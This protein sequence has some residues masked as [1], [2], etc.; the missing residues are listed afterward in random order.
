MKIEDI[1]QTMNAKT[2]LFASKKEIYKKDL[3]EK[4]I[5]QNSKLDGQK[6]QLV[7]M[8]HLAATT[9]NGLDDIALNIK[10]QRDLIIQSNM[11]VE[12]G[13]LGKRNTK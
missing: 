3:N 13:Q 8:N 5:N 2:N 9:S 12:L 1:Q 4:L 7:E 11:A 10:M 6:E